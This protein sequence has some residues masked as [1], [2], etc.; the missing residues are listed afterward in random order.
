MTLTLTKAVGLWLG[1]LLLLGAS[2]LVLP[3]QTPRVALSDL[4]E[5]TSVT[6]DPSEAVS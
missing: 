6:K 1:A 3:A 2:E 4:W 5:D